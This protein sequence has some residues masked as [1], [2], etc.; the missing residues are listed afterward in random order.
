MAVEQSGRVNVVEGFSD[1][2]CYRVARRIMDDG[3]FV[4]ADNRGDRYWE[5]GRFQVE[6]MEGRGEI[7]IIKPAPV[8]QRRGLMLNLF[9]EKSESGIF[10]GRK[11]PITKGSHIGDLRTGGVDSG[12]SRS[13]V[14]E[15][16]VY[17][18]SF[19]SELTSLAEN[20]AEQEGVDINVRLDKERPYGEFSSGWNMYHS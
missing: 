7:S 19:L 13:D 17:G 20:L 9:G 14:W 12:N 5:I 8:K 18:R 6:E 3:Y 10:L 4:S 16:D 15:L 2:L 1:R 11:Y